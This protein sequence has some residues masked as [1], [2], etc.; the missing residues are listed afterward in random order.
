MF[1]KLCSQSIQLFSFS[2][3]FTKWKRGTVILIQ[4]A[5]PP[6]AGPLE[7]TV[8][9]GA[10]GAYLNHFG[11]PDFLCDVEHPELIF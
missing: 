7:A 1:F 2:K 9:S 10:S 5:T 4:G 3:C 8:A 11:P 6:A